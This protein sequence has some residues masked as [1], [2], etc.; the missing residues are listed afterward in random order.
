MVAAA[1]T[2][3][4]E[5]AEAGRN[6][7]YRYVWIRDQCYAGQAV[8]AAGAHP[9][10][11]D[12]VRFVTDRVLDRRRP[13]RPRL[14][15]HRGPGPRPTHPGPARL[16]RRTQHHRQLGQQAIPTRRLRREPAAVRRRRPPRPDGHRLLARGRRFS[17]P[18]I[19]AR[20]TEPDAGIW[21]IDNRPWTHSRLT[22]AAG[23]RAIARHAAGPAAADWLDARRQNRRR[24]RRHLTAPH[25]PLATLTRR[26][27]RSTPRCC[28][29]RSAGR[30][31]P[32]TPAPSPPWTATCAT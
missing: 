18:R 22:C 14:H 32:T 19:A 7:D 4:P 10:L 17:P 15:Q 30:C 16:P 31:P 29:R 2:S 26:P 1:T 27:R 6:Y 13:P 24:H 20:W 3:L 5:R 11:D 28:Y 25:R 8:A 9:L 21:E 12:A 23:L